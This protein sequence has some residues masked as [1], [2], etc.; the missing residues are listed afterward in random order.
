MK[1]V[2]F[3]LS[4][5][6]I[7]QGAN[8]KGIE[9][10]DFRLNN[11]MQVVVITNTKV[12]AVSHMVW[13]KAGSQDEEAGQSGIAHFL[14]HL[15]F[16]GTK[17]VG[18][19]Q[20]SKLIAKAGGNDNAFTSSDYTAYFQNIARGE[21]ELVMGLEADRMKNL[22][23]DE[24]EVFKERDV[25]LEERSS[26]IDNNPSAMMREQMKSVLYQNHPY[27]RPLIGWRHE[28]EKLSL[29]D[30][31]KW[32]NNYYAPNNAV[33]IVSGDITAEELKPLAEKYY[34]KINPKTVPVRE[35]LQEPKHVAQRRLTFYD[36][37][38]SRPEWARY[39]KA[40]SQ[41]TRL[42]EHSYALI[43]LSHIL[44]ASNTSRLYQN[45]VVEDEIAASIGSYYDD[46]MLGPS[47][48]AIY[49]V[50]AKEHSLADVESA[51]EKE[52]VQIKEDGVSRSELKRAKNSL[53]AETIYA[54]EDLKSLAYVYGQAITTNAGIDY[55]KDW[56]KN[57]DAVTIS[58]IK[59]AAKAVFQAN[60]SVTGELRKESK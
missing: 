22:I 24:E 40:P 26:R 20:F 57:I 14:E 9:A 10:E 58:D 21:L 23:F 34:G 19:G 45:L 4:F 47:I 51:I 18:K 36:S 17:K 12:P 31:K 25:I 39:Y 1:L 53:I 27:G 56:E 8:A 32:Y 29:A 55:V 50:P 16:K 2:I 28:M 3:I 48:F 41:N 35:F 49:A 54:Q 11:G 44:G 15:M 7:T 33:L 38:V 59:E 43:V 42:K 46:L 6:V 13:Y 60:S 52:L 37:K 30:A 5:F